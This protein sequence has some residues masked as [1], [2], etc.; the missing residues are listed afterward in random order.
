[1]DIT[2]IVVS[3]LAILAC[4]IPLILVVKNKGKKEKE[5]KSVIFGMAAKSNAHIDLYDRWNNTIIG[6]DNSNRKLFFF[7]KAGGNEVQHAV[8]LND[9]ETSSIVNTQHHVKKDNYNV[10]QRLELALVSKDR[11]KRILLEFYNADYDSLT[12]VD[13]L[14]LAEKWSRN[15]NAIVSGDGVVKK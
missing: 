11:G 2:T 3:T 7:R 8:D 12:I 9:I 14:Q 4:I 13:E 15:V 10:T 1:M 5:F 6:M